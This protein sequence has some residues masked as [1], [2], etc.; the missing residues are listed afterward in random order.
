MCVQAHFLDALTGNR[1]RGIWHETVDAEHAIGFR[2][3]SENNNVGSKKEYGRRRVR[4]SII[5]DVDVL[6][7]C[8]RD[9]NCTYYRNRA[10][11]LRKH[12]MYTRNTHFDF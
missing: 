9:D 11:T 6:L 2:H 3:D 4:R 5:I 1:E 7:S 12:I 10:S 8:R